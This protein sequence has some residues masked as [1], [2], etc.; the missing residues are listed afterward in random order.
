MGYIGVCYPLNRTI[1]IRR[2]TWESDGPVEREQLIWHELGHCA[3]GRDH[4]N[5]LLPNGHAESI[6]N[7]S[8]VNVVYANRDYYIQHH[9]DYVKEM[10]P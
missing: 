8:S 9:A 7:S 3:M 4:N 10:W 1:F 2:D 6:M 5:K